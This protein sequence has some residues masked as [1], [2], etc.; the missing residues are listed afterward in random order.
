MGALSAS[1]AVLA[2]FALPQEP[3]ASGTPAAAFGTP[4]VAA[5]ART[6]RGAQSPPASRWAPLVEEAALRFGLPPDWIWRVMRAESGGR[7]MLRGRPITSPKGAMGLMQVMPATYAE[8]ARR[9][10]LGPDPYDP[11][12]N[13]LAGAG[14]LRLMYDRFGYPGLF[15]AYNAGPARTLAWLQG[16]Q[17]LP[18]ETRIY[19][20]KVAPGIAGQSIA[21][22]PVAPPAIAGVAGDGFADRPAPGLFVR[23]GIAADG[24][25]EGEETGASRPVL[26]ALFVPLGGAGKP[27]P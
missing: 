8:M 18:S 7:T 5:E 9:I 25:V 21:S 14:Y 22:A 11:R 17:R 13:I 1:L 23:R 6:G 2:A 15:A 24:P 19:L 20:S 3:P 10:G 12:D 16:R 4:A 26:N 27:L